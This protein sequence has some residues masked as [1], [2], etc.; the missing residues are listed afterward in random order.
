MCLISQKQLFYSYQQLYCIL[1]E[2]LQQFIEA[3]KNQW[4][5]VA[6]E[7]FFPFPG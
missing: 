2:Y 3:C 6:S 7:L 5:G 1:L 4:V